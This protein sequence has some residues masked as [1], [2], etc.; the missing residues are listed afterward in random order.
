MQTVWGLVLSRLIGRDDVVFG[1]TVSGRPAAL[2][3]VES[4]V[5][6]FINTLPVR[7]R[8][9][10]G[11]TLTQLL[12]RVQV[13]Q[14]DLLDHH[15]V[16]PPTIQQRA[17]AG[18]VFD[19]I[20]VF[21][22]YPVDAAGA[23]VTDIDGM[24]LLGVEAKTPT[25]SRCRC[26]SRSTTACGWTPSSCRT[27]SPVRTCSPWWT[28]STGCWPPW[29]RRRRA[30]SPNSRC[31]RTPSCVELDE[32]NATDH[33][34]PAATLADLF[35]AQVRRTPDAVALV[36]EGE[37]LTYAEF[38]ARANRLARHLIDL[39]VGP[40]SMVGLGIRRSLELMVGMYA[41]VKAGGAYVPIDP[42]HPADRTDYVLATADPV[43]VLT[44][45][46]DRFEVDP[47]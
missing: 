18:A 7:V 6:M 11:E 45:T 29:W 35:D 8:L 30:R 43:C 42:D 28:G 20:T 10:R 47:G 17:G 1:A 4:M 13:E 24:R 19:T 39:G 33:P 25:R 3:G 15:F 16:G 46:R 21:E 2:S 31:S 5:G 27:C 22:S 44:T 34:V 40:E 37:E 38:D 23:D 36:F 26:S 32:W 9:D 12:S 14:A 41:I